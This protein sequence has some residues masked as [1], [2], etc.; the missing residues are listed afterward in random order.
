MRVVFHCAW[1][2]A[3]GWLDVLRAAG[4]EFSFEPSETIEDPAGVEAAVVWNP[5]VGFFDR[6]PN[7]RLISILGAGGDYL[8]IPGMRLPDVPIS[9][10]VDPVMAERMAGWVLATTLY[11]HRQLDRYVVQQQERVWTRHEHPD[12]GEVGVGVMGLGAMGRAAAGL[13]ANV[14]Y[15]VAGWSR[16]PK[17]LAG[18]RTFAGD[19][20]FG[21][22]LARSNVLVCLLPL[23][24]STRGILNG[25]VF[26]A[27]PRGAIVLNAG[28]GA[29]LVEP[30]L[31]TALEAGHLG[32][33]ALD[34]FSD[35]PLPDDHPF[36]TH[37]NVLVTPHVASLTNP[38]TGAEQIVA[39]LRAVGAGRQP[40]NLI[41][42]TRGY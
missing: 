15:D 17:S 33:G 40:S 29:H 21:P 38:V 39:A 10:I 19:E 9:R 30:D 41:D 31:L 18:I 24:G 42:P 26:E 2:N 25:E 28:R 23:T 16:R 6:Y 4:P 12:F 34:V 22:F 11:F 20:Q 32:G 37:P 7:L 3:R 1:T 14:G 35:E 8:F 5:P 36:W 13:L 27:L